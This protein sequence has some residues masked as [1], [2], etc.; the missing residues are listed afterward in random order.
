MAILKGGGPFQT[1]GPSLKNTYYI[2]NWRGRLVMSKWPRKRGPPKTA[3]HQ[4]QVDDFRAANRLAKYITNEQQIP[5][6]LATQNS[7]FYPRDWAV[8]TMYGR[9]FSLAFDDGRTMYSMAARSDISK[10]LDILAQTPGG[11]LMRGPDFWEPVVGGLV[12][13]VLISNGPSVAASWGAAGPFTGGKSYANLVAGGV[14]LTNHATQGWWFRPMVPIRVHSMI[15]TI[16]QQLGRTY[17]AGIYSLNGNQIVDVIATTAQQAAVSN[18][19]ESMALNFTTTPTL[20]VGTEYAF[21]FTR[22]DGVGT[23][24]PGNNNVATNAPPLPQHFSYGWC[25]IASI[26]PA[27]L[28]V[29]AGKDTTSKPY[30]FNMIYEL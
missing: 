8:M 5:L 19:T 20:A 29:L 1:K 28:D 11:L 26:A 7:G 27:A 6:L 15:A 23:D 10:S 13:Q 12:G 16:A 30:P 2:R 21:M 17:F 4:K 24:R 18:F 3:E 25:R 14:N 9:A 22:D